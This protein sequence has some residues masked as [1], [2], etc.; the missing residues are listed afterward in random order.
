[1]RELPPKLNRFG[2]KVTLNMSA[3]TDYPP[4]SSLCQEDWKGN[5][6]SVACFCLLHCISFSWFTSFEYVS[7]GNGWVD[8]LSS[9]RRELIAPRDDGFIVFLGESNLLSAISDTQLCGIIFCIERAN[10]NWSTWRMFKTTRDWF[11]VHLKNES[12]VLSS[13]VS[14]KKFDSLAKCVM[15]RIWFSLKVAR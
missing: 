3:A 1:M 14:T 13:T 5:L 11:N 10:K 7:L 9:V 6:F 4:D 12:I 15:S 2:G 8:D